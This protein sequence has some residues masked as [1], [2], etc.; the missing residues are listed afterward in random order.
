MSY[1]VCITLGQSTE[2]NMRVS[3]DVT[4]CFWQ[5][6]IAALHPRRMHIQQQQ[7]YD[8]FTC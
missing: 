3:W 4:R 1:T 6:V 8:V 5:V 7:S 2:L